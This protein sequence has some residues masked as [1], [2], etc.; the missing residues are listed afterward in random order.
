MLRA[1]VTQALAEGWSAGQLRDV[2][3][4]N[5]AFGPVRALSIA[6]T[7]TAIARRRG[8]AVSAAAGG[9]DQKHW[10]VGEDDACPLC[11]NNQAVGWIALDDDF[12]EGDDPHPNCTCSIDYRRY[13]DRDAS[14]SS[15]NTS[16]GI[17]K[18][19]KIA[20]KVA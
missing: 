10:M 16:S 20:R 4:E 7:E 2:L 6:R 1:S 5:Y 12:P 14:L 18:F 3:R 11:L 8:G 15:A 19:R 9:A 17:G 13:S